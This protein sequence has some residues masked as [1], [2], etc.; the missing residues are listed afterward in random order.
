MEGDLTHQAHSGVC[1]HLL[2]YGLTQGFPHKLLLCCCM[3]PC[4]AGSCG[5]SFNSLAQ[6]CPSCL[7]VSQVTA[8]R[9]SL[10][11]LIHNVNPLQ[12]YRPKKGTG[13]QCSELSLT[14][15]CHVK[16]QSPGALHVHGISPTTLQP[17]MQLF[18]GH[19]SFQTWLKALCA[20]QRPAEAHIGLAPC[21]GAGP[22]AACSRYNRSPR[23]PRPLEY[24][25]SCTS[26]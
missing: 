25:P 23:L 20:A 24:R 15:Q 17:T 4:Y 9:A 18:S 6:L 16:G 12:L 8:C 11:Q 19:T 21:E 14:D 10:K 7:L 1:L 22:H 5:A 2:I 13:S 26:H 3:R